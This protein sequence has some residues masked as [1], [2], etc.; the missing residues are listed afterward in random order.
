MS[1]GRTAA[2]HMTFLTRNL[3]SEI[4]L[5]SAG[6]FFLHWIS[7]ASWEEGRNVSLKCFFRKWR[8]DCSAFKLHASAIFSLARDECSR[9]FNLFEIFQYFL[10][11]FIPSK[12]LVGVANEN[13][14]F[15]AI[16]TTMGL[17]QDLSQPRKIEGGC[18]VR[19]RWK[20]KSQLV[21]TR[22]TSSTASVD[23]IVLRL[24]SVF[25]FHDLFLNFHHQS[26]LRHN[27]LVS[28]L[29]RNRARIIPSLFSSTFTWTEKKPNVTRPNRGF[30]W[31][32]LVSLNSN[33]P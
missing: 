1:F 27:A 5:S 6:S 20:K 3:F 28:A 19:R 33:G 17:P 4:Q 25:T 12:Q 11:I 22:K 7:I 30:Y 18:M 24:A 31:S 13:P 2:L 23:W 10:A 21:D 16:S 8:V 32:I 26:P 14:A 15:L 29:I 9:N